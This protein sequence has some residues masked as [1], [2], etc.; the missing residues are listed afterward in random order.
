MDVA[1]RKFEKVLCLPGMVGSTCEA[2]HAS[3]RAVSWALCTVSDIETLKHEG[4]LH[5]SGLGDRDP[6][7]LMR[8]S[9]WKGLWVS[10][11]G[12]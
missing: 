12:R 5:S 11:L 2:R 4:V 6:F 7:F 3:F 9:G 8:A 10:G 1:K